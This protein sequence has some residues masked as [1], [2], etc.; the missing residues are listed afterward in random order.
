MW[1]G[2]CFW[3]D[4]V[5]NVKN[6]LNCLQ[7]HQSKL[8]PFPILIFEKTIKRRLVSVQTFIESDWYQ[9]ESTWAHGYKRYKT[10]KKNTVNYVKPRNAVATDIKTYLDTKSTLATADVC[11]G[12]SQR[13]GACS[14]QRT[15]KQMVGYTDAY[16]ACVWIKCQIQILFSFKY[17]G[18]WTR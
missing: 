17:H 18:H 13:A 4:T 2:L 14:T 16:Q 1:V 7:Q 15:Y 9:P 12:Q 6:C 5:Q 8:P 10:T 11:T 3:H